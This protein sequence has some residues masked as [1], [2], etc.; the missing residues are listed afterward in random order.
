M[1]VWDAM[2]VVRP[3]QTLLQG[4]PYK[5]SWMMTWKP[6]LIPRLNGAFGWQGKYRLRVP[7]GTVSYADES[8]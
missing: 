3:S 1:G 2:K 4:K 5:P 6:T 8:K 7:E